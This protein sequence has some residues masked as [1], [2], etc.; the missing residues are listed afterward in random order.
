MLKVRN[1]V[2]KRSKKAVVNQFVITDTKRAMTYFQSYKSMIASVW[3]DGVTKE[4]ELDMQYWN[5]S[6]TTSK[7]LAIF[8]REST[9][10]I[11]EKVKNGTYKL[12]DLNH[13]QDS[14]GDGENYFFLSMNDN[15]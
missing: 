9:K 5:Y 4:V 14:G 10:E 8:L 13:E 6:R 12:V 11:K 7:Y 2:S 1:M 3:S 15:Y